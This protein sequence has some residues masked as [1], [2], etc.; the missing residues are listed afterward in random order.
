[1]I[2]Y[3]SRKTCIPHHD[4]FYNRLEE[5]DKGKRLAQGATKKLFIQ[6]TAVVVCLPV[7]LPQSCAI[8]NQQLDGLELQQAIGDR[9]TRVFLF[10][11]KKP[12]A[13]Y[14]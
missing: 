13:G 6:I 4:V 3:W 5:E 14:F 12:K 1:M 11:A 7:T 8:I 9:P 2:F 10:E